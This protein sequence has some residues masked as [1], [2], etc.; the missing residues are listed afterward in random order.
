MKSILILLACLIV[1]V[2]GT[3]YNAPCGSGTCGDHQTCLN[4]QDHP[5]C[6]IN[7]DCK[8]VAVAQYKNGTW[9]E[10]DG[11]EFSK[12]DVYIYNYGNQVVKNVYI[13]TDC[14]LKFRNFNAAD[15]SGSFWNV[16]FDSHHGVFTLPAY[17][18]GIAPKDAHYFGYIIEGR[19]SPNLKIRRVD[20]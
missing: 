13:D 4:Y 20:F 18:T 1:C 6:V 15:C 11:K 3:N 14:T 16:N 9:C 5:Y 12:Y 8:M 19:Q 7:D 2:F 10:G 17:S